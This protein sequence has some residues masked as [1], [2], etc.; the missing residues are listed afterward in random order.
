[1][2]IGL[3]GKTQT[4][5]NWG[6]NPSKLPS[7][8]VYTPDKLAEKPAVILGLHPCGGSG[9]QYRSMVNL[10]S[11]ADK[12]GFVVIYPTSNAQQGFNCWD[13]NSAKSLKHDG[14][15]DSQGLA[16]MAKWALKQYNGDASK[17][18]AIGGSSG[19]MESNVLA[20][21]YPDVFKGAASYSGV[22]AA[23]WAGAP[24]ST[25]LS[26]DTTCPLGQ[27]ASKY[28][29]QQWVDLA[30]GCDPGYNGTY[31][32]MLIVHGT[33][34]TA[35]TINNLKAQLD[36]WSGVKGLTFTKNETNNPITNWKKIIYG[37]GTELVGYEV[38]GGGHIPPFQGDATL[39]FF[40]LM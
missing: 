25:P 28:S 33:A 38:Q 32:K 15:G 19:A 40:G 16:A 11:Y 10:D 6:D 35:V 7:I 30:K 29:Q 23:C 18:F 5:A 34:D 8:L 3:A 36:Q 1:M 9:S 2:P 31:P 4:I 14:G 21:T 13:A 39:S 20:A 17:V 12:L 24:Y 26:S 27:K 37:D 22:P